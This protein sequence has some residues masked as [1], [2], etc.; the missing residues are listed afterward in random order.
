MNGE[1]E[2]KDLTEEHSEELPE[3]PIPEAEPEVM[4]ARTLSR[5]SIK[6]K[7]IGLNA[8]TLFCRQLSTLVDV[9]IPLLKCLQI[10]HQRTSNPKLQ[11]IIQQV[12]Q[13]IRRDV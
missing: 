11:S 2:H 5:G 3:I 6:L 1:K 10:L 8:V 7:S 4:S 12:S 9:G 13:E